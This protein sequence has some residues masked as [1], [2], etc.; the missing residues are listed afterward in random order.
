MY[1]I[2][3]AAFILAFGA[4]MV[5]KG[6]PA[7]SL[8]NPAAVLSI[9]FAV[10]ATLLATS[11]FKLFTRGLNAAISRK[12][13]IPDDERLHAAELFR[14]LSKV[15]IAAA[16]FT[17]FVGF[18][19]MLVNW[20]DP[21][22]LV[23]A[24]ASALLSPILGIAVSVALFEPAVFILRH[25][26]YV[27]ARAAKIYPKELGDKLLELCYQSGLSAEEIENAVGIELR[28]EGRPDEASEL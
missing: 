17:A 3:I 8:A 27:Q 9:L 16:L 23:H 22:A 15:T 25:R 26:D 12:Y 14:L 1:L 6:L 4:P 18:T 7:S 11:S 28:T 13:Y 2:G 20:E 24:L 21:E 5:F 10:I 19:V